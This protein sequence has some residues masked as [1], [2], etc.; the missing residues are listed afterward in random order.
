MRQPPVLRGTNDIIR[1][2]R[3]ECIDKS[4]KNQ[5]PERSLENFDNGG[6][7]RPIDG[8]SPCVIIRKRRKEHEEWGNGG[9]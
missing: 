2:T 4:N 6:A 5:I 3:R 7:Q 1:G 8:R 9:Q